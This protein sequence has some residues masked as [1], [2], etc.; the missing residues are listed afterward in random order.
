MKFFR[1]VQGVQ[2]WMKCVTMVFNKDQKLKSLTN[3]SWLSQ[4]RLEGSR[5]VYLLNNIP[6]T[7]IRYVPH[8]K[9][10]RLRCMEMQRMMMTTQQE[11]LWP[12]LDIVVDSS[13][14]LG[15]HGTKWSDNVQLRIQKIITP[16]EALQPWS[17]PGSTEGD[18]ANGVYPQ[19]LPSN[20]SH[21]SLHTTLLS[22]IQSY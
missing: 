21:V 1:A 19:L 6:K 8:D 9:R 15:R 17:C 20:L 3:H 7:I 16:S 5:Q 22:E 13:L 2:D 12:T 4:N 10:N 14:T 11:K 18:L